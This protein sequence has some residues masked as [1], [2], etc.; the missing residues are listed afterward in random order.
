[1]K[2]K[3]RTQYMTYVSEGLNTPLKDEGK[4]NEAKGVSERVLSYNN[5]VR[6]SHHS[7][8]HLKTGL[9]NILTSFKIP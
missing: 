3:C 6:L 4:P 2:L 5:N 7:P 1:M 8:G 9:K